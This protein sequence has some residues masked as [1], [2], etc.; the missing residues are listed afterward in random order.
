MENKLS[1]ADEKIYSCLS[2]E[3][4]KSFFLFAGAGSG[5]T[6][7]L[8]RVLQ[9]FRNENIQELRLN[10]KKVA[11]IT[12]TNAACDEIKRRL[13]FDST[14]VVS[15]IHS[16]C[17]ELI[18]HFQTDIREWLDNNI[19]TELNTLKLAQSKARGRNKSF[20]DR[21][22]KIISKQKRLEN[23]GGILEFTYNPNGTNSSRDSLNHAEV[24][25]IASKF[26]DSKDL[27]QRILI[28][29]FPILL[30]DESQDTKKELIEALFKV[31]R[32]YSSEFS[33]GLFGDT[34]Q[35]IYTD[36]KRDLGE[37]L[38]DDW[39][40]PGKDINYRCSR[41]VITLINKVRG[42]QPQVPGENNV[43]GVAR[44]F[45]VDSNLATNKM[46]IEEDISSRMAS[47]SG[48]D[49]WRTP[50]KVK[51]L[52]L[53]HKMA[54]KRGGFLEFFQPL[55]DTKKNQTGLMDGTMPGMPFFINNLLPLVKAIINSDDFKV[56]DL[57]KN[58]SPLLDKNKLRGSK[59]Q[60]TQIQKAKK[61]VDELQKM[62]S[63]EANPILLDIVKKVHELEIFSVPDVLLPIMQRD[64]EYFN[65]P[66]DVEGETNPDLD[67]WDMALRSPFG[68]LVAYDEYIS[69]KSRFGTHQGIKGL[70]FPRVMV[71]LDDDDAGGFLFSYEK[72]LGAKELSDTDIKNE[73]EGKDS[74]V[75]RTR[76]LFYVTCSRAEES[77]A[78][79]AY[80]QNPNM[81]VNHAKSQGW[82]YEYE[83]AS[84]IAPKPYSS[85]TDNVK[86]VVETIIFELNMFDKGEYSY[87]IVN[88]L[89][90]IIRTNGFVRAHELSLKIVDVWKSSQNFIQDIE[91]LISKYSFSK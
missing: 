73:R 2:L 11:V 72:L 79:V 91:V 51:I 52:T 3:K 4:P 19:K 21:E 45:I 29:K 12:Y 42:C 65:A 74:T 56:A 88:N 15:T 47:F 59:E 58:S 41:R 49:G 69:D 70:E 39:I 31:Q 44:L 55:Y 13:E 23:L 28:R 75:E 64:D 90:R 77:L 38:P 61:A 84:F 25:Q 63:K 50:E 68:Q 33:L 17:W 87:V 37:N 36:G 5:K 71:I 7:S 76:R 48:D 78:V 10:G 89:Y 82:F 9:K 30:V 80:T 40:K 53:E 6:G 8:V 62:W 60:V 26:L 67:A 34:M 20:I 16:F 35:R 14:F 1:D 32:Y 83:I 22:K 18:R 81:V 86:K 66:N 27:M 43:E 46:E 24:I 57:I 54:A 85:D